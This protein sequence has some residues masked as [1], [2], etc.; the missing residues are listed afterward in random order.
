[1]TT[2]IRVV[3]AILTEDPKALDNM[4]HQAETFTDY[5]QI[6]IMD[7]KFVPSRSVNWDSLRI[8]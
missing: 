6:D 8:S 5:V 7:G 1:M 2:S 4:L 3:P